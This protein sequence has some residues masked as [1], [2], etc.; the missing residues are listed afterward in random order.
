[1]EPK[2]LSLTFKQWERLQTILIDWTIANEPARLI[3]ED[4]GPHEFIAYETVNE[5]LT[6]MEQM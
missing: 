2:T 6:K 4:L 5:I 1:M 3:A